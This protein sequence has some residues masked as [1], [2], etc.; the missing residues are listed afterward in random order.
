M[1][2]L[3]RLTFDNM[4]AHLSLLAG[5]VVVEGPRP[6]FAK[7]KAVVPEVEYPILTEAEARTKDVQ[8]KNSSGI[9]KLTTGFR[10]SYDA[11]LETIPQI[12]DTVRMNQK[13]QSGAVGVGD[14]GII[15]SHDKDTYLR[16]RVFRI[17]FPGVKDLVKSFG[18]R[19]DVIEL[20]EQPWITVTGKRE[21]SP[22]VTL[23]PSVLIEGKRRNGE[24]TKRKLEGYLLSWFLF[25]Y[26]G[27][28]E[29]YLDIIE[30]RVVSE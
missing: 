26:A 30:Y 8:P 18:W 23:P 7:L 15:R 13:H 20:A 6:G 29:N 1:H 21:D 27:Y 19:F 25:G 10:H 14:I 17:E 16:S 24:V 3:A 12:G 2:R 5:G 4:A 22:F 9:P 11:T 28:N